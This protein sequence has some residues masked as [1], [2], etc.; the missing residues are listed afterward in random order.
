MHDAL[1]AAADDDRDLARLEP[2]RFAALAKTARSEKLAQAEHA[3]RDAKEQA[4]VQRL[5]AETEQKRQREIV[6]QNSV[7]TD[8]ERLRD[9]AV[10]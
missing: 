3:A 10:R 9:S 5:A 7:S 8:G 1:E 2:Q 4:E 6:R